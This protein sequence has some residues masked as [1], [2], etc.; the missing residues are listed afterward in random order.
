MIFP[1][2]DPCLE[3]VFLWSGVHARMIVYIC[4]TLQPL[5]RPRYVAAIEE[6]VYMEGASIHRIPDVWLKRR[7]RPQRGAI[8]VM[9]ADAPVTVKVPQNEIHETLIE[10]I[11]RSSGQKLVTVIEVVSPTNKLEGPGRVS[12]LDKQKEVRASDAHLV[13]IDLLRAGQHVV[14]VPED[15]LTRNDAYD[16]LVC[17]NRAQEL[18]D[19]YGL[20]FSR[21][22]ERLPRIRIPL[23]TGDPDVKLELQPLIEQV[24][25]DGCYDDRIDYSKP[26]KPPLSPADQAWANQLIKKVFGRDGRNGSR[27]VKK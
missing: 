18:R 20:Y 10:I 26:C 6:R 7:R 3:N 23:A 16:Y 5:I 22:R 27:K 19:E 15:A 12:Y 8:A 4:N 24:Y 2:M 14:S 1:G 11:D 21:L 9:E 17:V 25:K 13:E